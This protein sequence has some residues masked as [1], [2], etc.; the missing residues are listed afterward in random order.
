MLVYVVHQCTILI[1]LHNHGFK[2]VKTSSREFLLVYFA[3]SSKSF[4]RDVCLKFKSIIFDI[5]GLYINVTSY[6]TV[7]ASYLDLH[8]EYIDLETKLTETKGKKTEKIN[9]DRQSKNDVEFEFTFN[10]Q[11]DLISINTGE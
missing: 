8:K 7:Q 6:P 10:F 3:S 4:V 11:V 9:N 2:L 5:N 1:V